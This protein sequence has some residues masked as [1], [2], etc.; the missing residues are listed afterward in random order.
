LD[1]LDEEIFKK[2]V[3]ARNFQNMVVLRDEAQVLFDRIF[4][5][6]TGAVTEKAKENVRMKIEIA[7]ACGRNQVFKW[8]INFVS[9]LWKAQALKE[10]QHEKDYKWNGD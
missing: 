1:I 6:W 3:L 8:Y 2:L 7:D 4:E 9:P 5:P 10:N